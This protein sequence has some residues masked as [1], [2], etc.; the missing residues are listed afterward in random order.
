M[1][2][3]VRPRMIVRRLGECLAAS[4]EVPLEFLDDRLW[5]VELRDDVRPRQFMPDVVMPNDLAVG[6]VEERNS[7]A[8][9]VE[10]AVGGTIRVPFG[11]SQNALWPKRQFF[12]LYDPENLPI[13]AEGIISRTVSCLEFLNGARSVVPQRLAGREPHDAPTRSIQ[14]WVHETLT[15]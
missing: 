2:K 13:D 11:L 9:V 4:F 5:S 1:L 14:L 6:G 12:R 15:G 3:L 8:T 7:E 10:W